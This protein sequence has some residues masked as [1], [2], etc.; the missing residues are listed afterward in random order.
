MHVMLAVLLL[1]LAAFQILVFRLSRR[2][3]N[4]ARAQEHDQLTGFLYVGAGAMAVLGV[5][6][7]ALGATQDMLA[8][9]VAILGLFAFLAYLLVAVWFVRRP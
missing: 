7:L 3:S 2:R 8:A 4:A 1:V 5:V 9:N 6:V